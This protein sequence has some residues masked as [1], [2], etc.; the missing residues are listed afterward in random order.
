MMLLSY[1]VRDQ[2]M[3]GISNEKRSLLKSLQSKTTKQTTAKVFIFYFV[4]HNRQK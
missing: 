1:L 4:N 2:P 3:Y